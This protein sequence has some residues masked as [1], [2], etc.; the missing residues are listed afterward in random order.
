MGAGVLPAAR[1]RPRPGKLFNARGRIAPEG[2]NRLPGRGHRMSPVTDC[3]HQP[4]RYS[5]LSACDHALMFGRSVV[6]VGV[7]HSETLVR[8]QIIKSFVRTFEVQVK[9]HA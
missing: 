2:G 3:A 9:L 5:G 6:F 7:L 1:R 4:G 8:V